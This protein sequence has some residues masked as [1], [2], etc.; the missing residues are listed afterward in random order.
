MLTKKSRARRVVYSIAVLFFALVV[1]AQTQTDET[2]VKNKMIGV[3]NRIGVSPADITNALI[4]KTYTDK[5]SGIQYIYLQQTYK[6]IPVYNSI[7]T[8]A[9]KG[10]QLVY[11]SGKFIQKPVQVT[12]DAQPLVEPADAIQKAASHLHIAVDK[13]MVPAQ[14]KEFDGSKKHLFFSAL[15]MAKRDIEVKL[16][17]VAD[18]LNNLH[19]AWNVNIDVAGS[20]DWW[21]VRV[22]AKTGRI[23]N[24]NNW[25]TYEQPH[26][27]NGKK[28]STNGYKN[29]PSPYAAP[30]NNV[31]NAS[32]YVIPF[33]AENVTVKS[34]TAVTNPWEMAGANNNA[35]TYGWNY[36]GATSYNISRGNNVYAYDDSANKNAP[37]SVATSL[38]PLP[39]LSFLFTPDFTKS[40]SLSN[41][42]SAAITNLFYWN[43]LM[44]DVMYQYG[45][46]EAAGNFQTDNMNR[47][48]LGNDPVLAEA[49]DGS[50]LDNANFTAPDDGNSGRMQMYLW[51]TLPLSFVINKP[52]AL[53]GNYSSV[54]SAFS[55][56]NKLINVGPISDSIAL[57][58]VDTLA[59]SST[60]SA[61]VKG[62]IALI[63]RGSCNFTNKVMN[64]QNA[65]AVAVVMVNIQ[66]SALITMSGTNDTITI[67]AVMISYEDGTAISN[68]IKTGN[69]VTATLTGAPLLDGDF[70]NGIM[71]HE[72][73]H[74]VS[75]RLTGGNASCLS[76]SEKPDEGWSDYFGL[77]MTQN[78]TAT[79]LS[80]SAKS[81]SIGTYV[82]GE[83]VNSSG[84]RTY[85]YSTN[86][87][88]DP[89]TYTDLSSNGEVHYIGETWCSAL[90]DMTWD[91]IKQEGSINS[92]IYDANGTGGNVIALK[93]VIE[94]E[95]LQPCN[96][97]F[98]DARDAIIAA[99]S[100]LFNGRHK[101]TIWNAFARRGMGISAVQGSSDNTNDQTAAFDVPVLRL[102]TDS[103]PAVND[104]FT[105]K[106]TV[107]CECG[108]PQSGYQ[109]I[110]TIPAGFTLLNIQP[111]ATLHDSTVVWDASNF[112]ALGQ[113]NVYSLTLTPNPAKGCTEDTIIYDDRETHTSGGFASVTAT[114][115]TGWTVSTT[116]AYSLPRSWHAPDPETVSDFSLM[117][118]AFTP[119]GFSV[120]S[121]H[122]RFITEAD[123]DGGMIDISIN[124]GASWISAAPL[125]FRNGYN[126][127]IYPYNPAD[128][129]YGATPMPSFTGSSKDTG[130]IQSFINLSSFAG[131]TI[132]VRFRMYTDLDNSGTGYDGWYVDDITVTNGC[133][134]LQHIG[135]YNNLNNI[136]G[137]A[138]VGDFN[139]DSNGVVLPLFG[140]FTAV[141]VHNISALLRW[142]T[143]SEA[144][145]TNFIIERS[146]DSITYTT[147]AT[148]ALQG[149]DSNYTYTDYS[150]DGGTNYYRI[151]MVNNNGNTVATSVV[152]SV[153]F[154][155]NSSGITLIPNPAVNRTTVLIDASFNAA[156]IAVFDMAGRQVLRATLPNGATFYVMNTA[157]LSTGMYIIKIVSASG[158]V[159]NVK[160][161][162]MK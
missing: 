59:C 152:R 155:R 12:E 139:I 138:V 88:V 79:H 58:T 104:Q 137:N 97:G 47:G 103:L 45:F 55:T 102:H 150:P 84:I 160:L 13:N 72:Y 136:I 154:R 56:A 100:I 9:F 87:T 147:L 159:K 41:N 57:Y 7:K 111:Q 24:K 32:Y 28:Q 142:T 69:T 78:W 132:K 109:L 52:A 101:C 133:G 3:S 140:D 2:A 38:T 73:G 39:D 74:G 151:R 62:K 156:A 98:L 70:D 17:W 4:S 158:Q 61:N 6:N 113:T 127:N 11:S 115:T 27:T 116:R 117:S 43:N 114:G 141:S 135:L 143:L 81:R 35:T 75:H 8:I 96:P 77:M 121:F 149:A 5:S 92:N 123:A 10:N 76:N 40:T 26:Q 19:L 105:T 146:G 37:G 31:T 85:P 42:K 94:G 54:E 95:K 67:P 20:P 82:L 129:S 53:A 68:S 36:D 23:I 18:S 107:N 83:S 80:D 93:L 48:G 108:L 118:N 89:H 106:L 51:N 126:G 110:D 1:H 144:G 34:F 157:G 16:Y 64:A 134:G 49:H 112:T 120:L 60:L 161:M 162:V 125:F 130:F 66:G 44:H 65:G 33:P 50:G 29:Q 119:T 153:L 128:S 124:N 21:N 131:K 15:K 99:D 148:A 90:W 63:Y 122:H 145:A 91:I 71:C 86:M 46:D 30:P 22:D 25:T 14:H